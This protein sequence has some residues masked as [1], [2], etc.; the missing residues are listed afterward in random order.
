[1]TCP[2][3]PL[4]GTWATNWWR[5]P[6][7]CAHSCSL[8]PRSC[9]RSCRGE[10]REVAARTVRGAKD[11]YAMNR[12]GM[13][14]AT[15]AQSG[16]HVLRDRKHVTFVTT[17]YTPKERGVVRGVTSCLNL[18]ISDLTLCHLCLHDSGGGA[19][20]WEPDGWPASTLHIVRRPLSSTPRGWQEPGYFCALQC[21]RSA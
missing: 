17:H 20:C 10:Q 19:S 13:C 16:G 2:R 6:A 7:L 11:S 5:Q 14:V 1:M 12:I 9:M 21:C 8:E 15:F 18:A 4:L 3:S